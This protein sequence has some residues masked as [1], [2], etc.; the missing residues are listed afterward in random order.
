MKSC[1]QAMFRKNGLLW[2]LAFACFSSTAQNNSIP[3]LEKNNNTVRLIVH[4]NPFLIH[5]GEL[6]NSSASVN[7]YMLPV[8]QKLKAM[9]VNTVL[10]PVYWEL[11]EP[12]ENKFDFTLVDS[13]IANAHANGLHLVLLWF[14]TL[15]N[16]MSCYVPQWM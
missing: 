14:G 7:E 15:K 16:S 12:E 2:M 1:I 3:H 13:L 5:G 10:M 9:Q 6:G 8:W 4:N 11:I